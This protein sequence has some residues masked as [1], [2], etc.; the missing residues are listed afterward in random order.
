MEEIAATADG[1]VVEEVRDTLAHVGVVL[2]FILSWA[3]GELK[4]RPDV[5][6]RREV[7]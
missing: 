7:G 1:V 3:N 4:L 5:F 2:W 6:Y